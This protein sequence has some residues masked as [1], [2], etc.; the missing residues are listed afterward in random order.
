MVL[1]E[2]SL[3]LS[4]VFFRMGPEESSRATPVET[5]QVEL[6]ISHH[7]QGVSFHQQASNQ[8]QGLP[9]LWPVIDQVTNKYQSP[10]GVMITTLGTGLVAESLQQTTQG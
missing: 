8:L 1:L 3:V 4:A 7:R 10:V 2:N 6:V 5:D 9:L